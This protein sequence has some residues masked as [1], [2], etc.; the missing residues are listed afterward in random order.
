MTQGSTAYMFSI[1]ETKTLTE[2]YLQKIIFSSMM[3]K[4]IQNNITSSIGNTLDIEKGKF[5]LKFPK[6]RQIE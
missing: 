6:G 5:K 4:W 2:E 3:G 1:P